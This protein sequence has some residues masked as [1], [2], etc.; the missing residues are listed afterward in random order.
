MTHR[1]DRTDAFLTEFEACLEAQQDFPSGVAV[2]LDRSAFY[3]SAG[4]QPHDTGRLIIGGS[5]R[6]VLEVFEKNGALWHLLDA[7]P[8]AADPAVR[9]RIDW[10]RRFDHMQQHSGQHLLSQAFARRTGLDTIAVHIGAQ[11]C[12]LD[13]PAPSIDAAVL[14]AVE[15]DAN[16]VVYDDRALKIYEVDEAQVHLVPLRTAP[17]VSGRVRIVEIDGYDWSACGGTHVRGTGQIG[18]IKLLRTERRA[19]STRVTFL[20]G[21]RALRDYRTMHRDVSE[22]AAGMSVARAELPQAVTRLRDEARAAAKALAAAQAQLDELE[23]RDL[24]AAAVALP[25]GGRAVAAVWDD[26]DAA[27][28]RNMAKRLTA[29]PGVVALLAVT[30]EGGRAQLCFARSHDVALDA[31]P[32]L[33]ATLQSLGGAR[34]GG[35]PDFAQG[36]GIVATSAVLQR[37]LDQ[38]IQELAQYT[39]DLKGYIQHLG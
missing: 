27:A 20:C 24:L 3:P 18:I 11:E 34:G 21:A 7:A 33:R 35:T 28:L 9:G 25:G 26:R 12:T 5:E 23:A 22:L 30:G 13:L 16:A 14:D 15:D 2:R 38:R 29:G 10:T 6:K 39:G 36:G 8:P 32:L 19:E 1:L 37:A 4:G 31:A 17:K